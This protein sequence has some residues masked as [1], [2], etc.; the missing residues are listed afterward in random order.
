VR[1]D[2]VNLNQYFKVLESI[3]EILVDSKNQD[4]Y[5]PLRE[6]IKGKIKKNLDESEK[7]TDEIDFSDA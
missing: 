7:K 6:K 3:K 2:F 5:T 4:L 1:N